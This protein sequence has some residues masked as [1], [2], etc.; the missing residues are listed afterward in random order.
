MQLFLLIFYT[1]EGDVLF[2]YSLSVIIC[3]HYNFY[4]IFIFIFKK[5][6]SKYI[7]WLI[8]HY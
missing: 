7:P 4:I 1:V 8:F 3:F 2:F 6:T 5:N